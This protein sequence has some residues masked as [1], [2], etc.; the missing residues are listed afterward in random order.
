VSSGVADQANDGS[1]RAVRT[2]W[3]GAPLATDALASEA[4][5][6]LA[7]LTV[8]AIVVAFGIAP[9]P[10]LAVAV[11]CPA[12][13]VDLRERRLPDRWAMSAATVLVMMTVVAELV[14]DPPAVTSLVAG[15]L[16]MAG[17]LLLLHLVS[18]R[19]MGFG[20]VKAA[21]VLGAALG[22]ID[23]RL[24]LVTLSI[25]AASAAAVGI[26]RRLDTI[27]FG[28]FLVAATALT[29]IAS[30]AILAPLSIGTPQ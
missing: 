5:A 29:L 9:A 4:I 16:V 6:L 17:P 2:T 1:K 3:G 18:P 7:A 26:A 21:I 22:W 30:D 14:G 15:V 27:V 28:P 8:A 11:L 12:A 13:L 19:A 25:A 20:D 10:T 23:W 24:G